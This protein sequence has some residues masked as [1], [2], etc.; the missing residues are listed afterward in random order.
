MSYF[1]LAPGVS[2]P[3][4]YKACPGCTEFCEGK[5][6]WQIVFIDREDAWA[7]HLHGTKWAA[8]HFVPGVSYFVPE[9]GVSCPVLYQACPVF[10]GTGCVGHASV[11]FS[12]LFCY[13]KGGSCAVAK[14]CPGRRA[15]NSQCRGDSVM[16]IESNR[17]R[18]PGFAH[19]FE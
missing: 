11:A 5:A 4:L 9:P 2:C 12:R 19:A 6:E 10:A 18:P 7:D 8:S 17:V 14:L 13:L 1:V 3:T 16:V 15:E